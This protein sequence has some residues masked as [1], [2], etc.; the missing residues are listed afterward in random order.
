MGQRGPKPKPTKLRILHGDRPDRI[1]ADEPPAPTE[2]PVFP[3]QVDDPELREVWDYTMAQL[4]AMGIASAA[5]RDALLC[6]CQAVV[7]HRAASAATARDGVM[8]SHTDADGS[9]RQV[10]HPA[11][12]AQRDAATLIARF[13]G[14]FGLSPSARSEINKGAATTKPATAARLLSG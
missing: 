1:N 8:L 13:A 5:D 9:V 2:K 4:G 7:V 14:H 12:A 11:L 6:F 3:S 10:R